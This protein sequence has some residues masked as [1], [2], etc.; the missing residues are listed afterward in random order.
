MNINIQIDD[1]GTPKEHVVVRSKQTTSTDA[2][3]SGVSKAVSG[4][5]GASA[6]TASVDI[7]APPAWLSKEM[8][9][10][11][12]QGA[13]A[14]SEAAIEGDGGAGPSAGSDQ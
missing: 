11:N 13:S 8:Q 3:D 7:G 12:N 14:S 5:N 1:L 10:Q 2:H 9:E 4:D 6:S